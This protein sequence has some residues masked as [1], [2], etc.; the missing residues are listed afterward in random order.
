MLRGSGNRGRLNSGHSEARRHA[1]M[2]NYS[3]HINCGVIARSEATKQSRSSVDENGEIA[4][5][6]LV[7][8]NDDATSTIYC[9]CYSSNVLSMQGPCIMQRFVVSGR[10]E[11]LLFGNDPIHDW[12][13]TIRSPFFLKN[14]I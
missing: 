1:G 3:K 7:A 14:S 6:P 4:T 2:D 5:L 9:V 13:P 10:V 12:E 8:R 11:F